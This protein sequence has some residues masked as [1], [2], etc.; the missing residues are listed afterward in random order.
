MPHIELLD[1]RSAPRVKEL[2]LACRLG[3]L[4][5]KKIGFLSNGKANANLLLG[6]IEKLLGARLGG[7]TIVW[8][9]KGAAEPAPENVLESLRGCDTAITAIAD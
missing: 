4:A 2:P 6:H 5:G 8:R 1:P 9:D 3:S 7:L